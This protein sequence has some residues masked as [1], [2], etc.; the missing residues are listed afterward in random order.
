MEEE[1]Q[2][3][4]LWYFIGKSNW[5]WE[6]CLVSWWL[7]IDAYILTWDARSCKMHDA[8]IKMNKQG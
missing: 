6:I 5:L 8:L 7:L 4:E 3:D 1:V 2:R